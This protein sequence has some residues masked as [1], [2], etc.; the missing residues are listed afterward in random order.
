MNDYSVAEAKIGEKQ[1]RQSNLKYNFT[2]YAFFEKGIRSVCKAPEAGEFFE[3]FCVKSNLTGCKITFIVS[4]RKKLGEQDLPVAPPIILCVLPR[5]RRLCEP[6]KKCPEQQ[7]LL[8][9]ATQDNRFALSLRHC[10]LHTTS[11]AAGGKTIH[12]RTGPIQACHLYRVF[13]FLN[14]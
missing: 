5:F 14:S 2:Q 11:S 3:N 8:Q 1:S 12:G 4:Y 13:L 6:G 7:V 10:Q 9:N